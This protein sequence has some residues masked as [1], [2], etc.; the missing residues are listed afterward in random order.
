MLGG[1]E[2]SDYESEYNAGLYSDRTNN[3]D[4]QKPNLL[5]RVSKSITNSFKSNKDEASPN[6]VTSAVNGAKGVYQSVANKI[7]P[8]EVTRPNEVNEVTRPNDNVTAES[9]SVNSVTVPNNLVVNQRYKFDFNGGSYKNQAM[10]GTVSTIY[11]ALKDLENMN[12]DKKNGQ[13]SLPIEW[14]TTATLI[15]TTGGRKKGS[16]KH[17]KSKKSK[18]SRRRLGNWK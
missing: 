5:A 14:I 17:K 10:Y 8:N 4:E 7:R 3:Y 15:P 9:N 13:L 6:F 1:S 12:N 2:Q 16:V 11:I 18:K